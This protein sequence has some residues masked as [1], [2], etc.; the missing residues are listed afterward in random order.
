MT[1]TYHV[2]M[3]ALSL[4]FMTRCNAL[5]YFTTQSILPVDSPIDFE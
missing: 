1:D 4:L 3:N 5:L 2:F